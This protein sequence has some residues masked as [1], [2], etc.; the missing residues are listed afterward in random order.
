MLSIVHLDFKRNN[1]DVILNMVMRHFIFIKKAKNIENEMKYTVSHKNNTTTFS[2]CNVKARVLMVPFA[3]N[4]SLIEEVLELGENQHHAWGVK[5]MLE[6]SIETTVMHRYNPAL[7][8]FG[9]DWRVPCVKDYDLIYSNHNRL[10]RT[11]IQNISGINKTPIV[12]LVYAGEQLF[13]PKQHHG[14]M[15]MTPH[16]HTR[17]KSL[18]TV[19]ACYTPW[20][21]DPNSA[22]HESFEPTGEHFIST[23]VTCRDFSVLLSAA[24]S[25]DERLII[26][27]RGQSF[28]ESSSNVKVVDEMLSPWDIRELYKGAI[29]GLVILKRD[30]KKRM[31]VGWTNMLELMAVGLPIIKTRTGSLDDIVDLEKIGAG[32][33]IEPESHKA[34]V[35]AMNFLRENPELRISMGQKGAQY[36]REHLTMQKFA[37]PLIDMV[38]TVSNVP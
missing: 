35:D 16:A 26:A 11:P 33:L 29:A 20:G 18:P 38:H 14:I 1:N 37:Q 15:C 10:I 9:Q 5:E 21:L 23:G 6:A 22:L 4:A 30:D 32:I 8:R 25:V 34:L 2:P 17:F 28:S 19:K 13:M 3:T 24:R 36:V 12:S 7:E 31:A 27:A